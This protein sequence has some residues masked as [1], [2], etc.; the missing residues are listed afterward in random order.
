ML[1]TQ[2]HRLASYNMTSIR[3]VKVLMSCFNSIL[4]IIFKVLT[5]Q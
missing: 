1:M 5:P 4:D 3:I 2:K